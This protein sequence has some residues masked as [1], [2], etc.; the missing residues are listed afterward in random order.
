VGDQ[1]GVDIN[2]L[3]AARSSQPVREKLGDIVGLRAEAAVG[4][5]G[6]D[7]QRAAVRKGIGDASILGPK[8]VIIK[9]SG[10]GAQLYGRDT[11][12]A[13]PALPHTNVRDPAVAG[14]VF[15]GEFIGRLVKLRTLNEN[16]YRQVLVTG[17]VL[18][19]HCVLVSHTV[20]WLA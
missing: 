2:A 1:A 4:L 10:Y 14:D 20:K 11:L 8:W 5:S 19:S 9:S 6:A 13:L 16:A 17:T 15:A 18:A 7:R 12:L 3:D